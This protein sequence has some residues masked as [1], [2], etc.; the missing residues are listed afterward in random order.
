MKSTRIQARLV[1][2][3]KEMELDGE[4]RIGMDLLKEVR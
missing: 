1:E 3:A 4:E 2:K